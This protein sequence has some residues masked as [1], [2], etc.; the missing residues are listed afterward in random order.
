MSRIQ[1]GIRQPQ[2]RSEEYPVLGF[3]YRMTDIQAAVGRV[4]LRRLPG[5]LLRREKLAAR[6]HDRLRGIPRLISPL[7]PPNVKP[8]Y[9]SYA[10][11]VTEDYPIQ[12][13]QLMQRLL[14]QG[15]STRRGIMNAHQEERIRIFLKHISNRSEAREI[16]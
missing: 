6:Y 15:I 11:R 5:L 16:R 7:V 2:L 1:L 9:Q 12:R 13:T 14:E 4:Q 3:N 8:N 10:V